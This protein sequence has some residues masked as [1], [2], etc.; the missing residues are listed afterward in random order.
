MCP[1]P[2]GFE[3]PCTKMTTKIKTDHPVFLR[4]EA[5]IVARGSE[6]R[7]CLM[8]RDWRSSRMTARKPTWLPSPRST[9]IASKNTSWLRPAPPANCWS[10]RSAWRSSA[11]LPVRWAAMS[12]SQAG[13]SRED[14]RRALHRRSARQASTRPG[15]TNALTHLPRAQRS[16]GDQRR[17]G[18]CLDQ[19][20]GAC[21]APEGQLITRTRSRPPARRPPEWLPRPLGATLSSAAPAGP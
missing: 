2:R 6:V 11:W 3:V 7:S 21:G 12:R 17:H 20:S 13:W 16:S 8:H 4:L 10:R 15:H 9:E 14:R 5:V 18:G 19:L 1:A